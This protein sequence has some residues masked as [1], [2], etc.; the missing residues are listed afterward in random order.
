MNHR[1]SLLFLCLLLMISS[2]AVAE[3]KR[4][5]LLRKLN[6]ISSDIQEVQQRMSATE[7]EL[8]KLEQQLATLNRKSNRIGRNI[9]RLEGQL[10]QLDKQRQQQ[11]KQHQKLLKDTEGQRQSMAAILRARYEYGNNSNLKVLLNQDQT[12][13]L[14]RIMTWQGYITEHQSERIQTLQQ[15]MQEL[16]ASSA[17]LAEQEQAIEAKRSKQLNQRAALKKSQNAQ[18]SVAKQLRQQLTKQKN[19]LNHLRTNE[20]QLQTLLESLSEVL[21]DIPDQALSTPFSSR[22]AQ[23]KWPLKGQL[24]TD[25]NS[26]K[27]Q[28]AYIQSPAG[29]NIHGIAAGR[30]AFADYMRGYGLLLIIDHGEGYMSLYGQNESL[31]KSVGDWVSEGELI[32]HSGA[33][34]GSHPAGLYFEIRAKGKPLKPSQWC[35][36]SPKLNAWSL[37]QR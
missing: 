29:S 3:S 5:E 1:M 24:A 36:S 28:G 35:Y 17:K 13:N 21:S 23:L 9:N 6:A 16:E 7:G 8:G 10:K 20:Q 30:V 22:K 15:S 26:L 32:A 25:T 14:Q 11:L 12:D 18:L 2:T 34:N 4:D 27:R 31:F 37:A 33:G 19:T